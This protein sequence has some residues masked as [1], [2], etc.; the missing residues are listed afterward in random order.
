MS[1]FDVSSFSMTSFETGNFAHFEQFQ[2]NS[3][4]TN[5]GQVQI[6]PIFILANFG[7]ATVISTTLDKTFDSEKQS[8]PSPF[9]KKFKNQP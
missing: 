7:H 4:F 6:D 1:K 8:K 3:H 5:I 9:D 2:I